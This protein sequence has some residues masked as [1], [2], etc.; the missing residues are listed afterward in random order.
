MTHSCINDD[1]YPC[2]NDMEFF[3]VASQHW[4]FMQVDS[5]ALTNIPFLELHPSHMDKIKIRLNH[6]KG[7]N[8][9]DCGEPG[10]GG[11]CDN[12]P[13][14]TI[15]PGTCGGWSEEP[16]ITLDFI[17]RAT[18][19]SWEGQN[20]PAEQENLIK[21]TEFSL[22]DFMSSIYG[23]PINICDPKH[24]IESLHEDEGCYRKCN[25]FGGDYP[26][27]FI[28]HGDSHPSDRGR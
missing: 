18:G 14:G 4:F 6:I 1:P 3:A 2:T 15:D 9:K 13:Q 26:T 10:D 21:N 5:P 20:L 8:I 27:D 23:P 16:D 11:I 28:N 17:T 25:P 7:H 12:V 22:Y 24:G 19:W